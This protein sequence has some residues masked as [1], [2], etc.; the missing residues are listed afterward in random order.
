MEQADGKR[1]KR[2]R[3]RKAAVAAAAVF[4]AVL[5]MAA[6]YFGPL[7]SQRV[8]GPSAE[9]AIAWA[10][11]QGGGDY[12]FSL[13]REYTDEEGRTVYRL[14]SDSQ[15]AV[16]KELR[17]GFRWL[18]QLRWSQSVVPGPLIDDPGPYYKIVNEDELRKSYAE[19][20]SEQWRRRI[21]SGEYPRADPPRGGE[22]G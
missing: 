11:K 10:D 15:P 1:R 20:S 6:L 7:V 8:E 16:V 18:P 22:D 14:V 3:D 4:V 21:E 17:Y 9:T 13:E 5:V 2:M 12:T 19:W